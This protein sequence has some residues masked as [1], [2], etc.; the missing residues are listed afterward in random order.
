[1]NAVATIHVPPSG[2]LGLMTRHRRF[3]LY[4]VIGVGAVVTDVGLYAVLTASVSMHPLVA[5]TISTFTSMA[6]S[7]TANAVLNF[8]VTNQ[9]LLRFMSFTLVTLAG[10]LL[11]TTMIAVMVGG[12]GI[13]ALI[14]KGVTLPI[15]LVLQFTLNKKV[16]FAT[17]A[18]RTTP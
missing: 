1:M 18:E 14:A 10:Y 13:G 9:I 17:R 3:L 7:F 4:A 16:T 8:R 15:V 6:C 2:L 5:N 11:S 12:L